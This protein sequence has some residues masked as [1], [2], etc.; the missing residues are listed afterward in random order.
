MENE[1]VKDED[2]DMER[3]ERIESLID[4]VIR[5]RALCGRQTAALVAARSL[6]ECDDVSGAPRAKR[7]VEFGELLSAVGQVEEA[8][9]CSLVVDEERDARPGRA[10]DRRQEKEN[11]CPTEEMGS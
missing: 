4:S 3:D 1:E 6:I 8:D 11:E 2:A 9:H 7:L 10:C 5:V